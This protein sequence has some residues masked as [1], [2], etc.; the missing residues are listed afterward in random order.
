MMQF[1]TSNGITTIS[2]TRET[3]RECRQIEE[4]QDLSQHARVTD[5]TPMQTS[6]EVIDPR[7]SSAPVETRPRRPGKELTQLDDTEERPYRK[8]G[9]DTPRG[10]LI[11]G[12]RS[13]RVDWELENCAID[14]KELIRHGPRGSI[15]Y[16]PRIELED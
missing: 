16:W 6:S 12:A 14:F 2:T 4:A 9:C 11:A 8:T 10:L 1:L 7:V 5:P 3:L 15:P 13:R